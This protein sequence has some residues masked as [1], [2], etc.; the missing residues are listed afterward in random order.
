MAEPTE[1][2]QKKDNAREKKFWYTYEH[3]KPGTIEVFYLGKGTW[4]PGEKFRR[5]RSEKGRSVAWRRTVRKYGKPEVEIVGIF[6]A[7]N[8]AFEEEKRLILAY[9]RRDLGAG[10]LVN[11]TD[12]GE[13]SGGVI[14]SKERRRNLSIFRT[15]KFKGFMSGVSKAV[16]NTRTGKVY[17]SI[18]EAAQLE[19]LDRGTLSDYLRGLYTNPTDLLFDK[20]NERKVFTPNARPRKK[21]SDA[22]RKTISDYA[23]KRIGALH[24]GSKSVINIATGHVYACTREA[25]QAEGFTRGSLSDYLRGRRKN[26]TSLRYLDQRLLALPEISQ[27]SQQAHV[28]SAPTDEQRSQ[29][30]DTTPQDS[31]SPPP[32]IPT[33]EALAAV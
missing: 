19:G 7:E 11:F 6:D 2:V 4:T 25:A 16:K 18:A 23:K 5:A 29:Q 22:Q 33:G 21:M 12:G 8:D 27:H 9:G 3:L 13:G 31:V 20:E 30:P 1:N 15:G 32:A 28:S 26:K 10:P 14:V 17:G 24:P